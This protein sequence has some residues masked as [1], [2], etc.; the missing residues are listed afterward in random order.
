[1]DGAAAEVLAGAPPHHAL[2]SAW[3]TR[4][5]IGLRQRC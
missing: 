1:M 3:V 2:K 5:D 4:E